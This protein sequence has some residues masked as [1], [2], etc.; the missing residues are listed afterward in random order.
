MEFEGLVPRRNGIMRMSEFEL[1]SAREQIATLY[2]HG[3]YIGKS[4]IGKFTKLLFQLDSFYVE[5]D[6]TSY[7]V[8]IHKIHCTDST[9]ILDEYLEQIDVEYLVT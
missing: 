9:A 3:V 7:R 1:L 6:Y 5:I 8:A 4:K 2:Q